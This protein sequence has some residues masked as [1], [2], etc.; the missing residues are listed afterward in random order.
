MDNLKITVKRKKMDGLLLKNNRSFDYHYWYRLCTH[1]FS[2]STTIK[3]TALRTN[4][5]NKNRR[6]RKKKVEKKMIKLKS[7][8]ALLMYHR[9]ATAQSI[10]IYKFVIQTPVHH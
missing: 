3:T 1:K 4:N 2:T 8:A 6:D 10:G 7:F 5:Q 9:T